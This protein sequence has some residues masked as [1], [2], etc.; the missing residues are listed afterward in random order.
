[1]VEFSTIK[2][3]IERGIEA[4]VATSEMS[5]EDVKQKLINDWN[6]EIYDVKRVSDVQNSWPPRSNKK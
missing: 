4:S 6:K 1:M 2:Y 5:P 3:G